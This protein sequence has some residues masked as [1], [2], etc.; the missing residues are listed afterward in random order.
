MID[1]SSVRR[2]NRTPIFKALSPV[3]AKGPQ[4]DQG[5]PTDMGTVR[6]A[7]HEIQ[8]SVPFHDL[9]PLQLVW[10][11]NYLKYFDRA[12]FALF[13]H[14]GVDL[15]AYSTSSGY[16]FPVTRTSTKHIRPLRYRDDFVVRATVR[17][18]HIRI[19]LDFEIRLVKDGTV[20][21]RGRGEQV[22]VKYPGDEL[23]L[24][25]PPE[26]ENALTLRGTD[27]ADPA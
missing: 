22:A 25:I 4:T 3:T 9:D 17:E 14:C 21:T 8:L 7:S 2:L 23:M 16:F 5:N 6:Y 24:Q 26:I 20:T 27:D 1:F 11:G 19:V 18:A 12:R 15:H 10:H 13:S